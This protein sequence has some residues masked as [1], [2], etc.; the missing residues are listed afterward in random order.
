LPY[1]KK[2]IGNDTALSIQYGL[3]REITRGGKWESGD[4]D[5]GFCAGDRI[6]AG[7]LRHV[8]IYRRFR[9]LLKRSGD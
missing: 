7:K 9:E 5:T 4:S 1:G 2:L 6:A 3:T 8:L